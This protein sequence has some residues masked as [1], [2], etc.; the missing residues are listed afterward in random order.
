[1]IKV[2]IFNRSNDVSR[3]DIFRKLFE[4]IDIFDVL[5]RNRCEFC[6]PAGVGKISALLVIE[7]AP[8]KG[9]FK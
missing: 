1:M 3:F 5:H 6:T 7:C 9:P 8:L 4:C 2:C